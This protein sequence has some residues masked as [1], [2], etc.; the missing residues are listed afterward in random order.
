MIGRPDRNSARPARTATCWACQT[1]RTSHSHSCHPTQ[2]ASSARQTAWTKQERARRGFYS[3][4]NVFFATRLQSPSREISWHDAARSE[5]RYYDDDR[6][7]ALAS[8]IRRDSRIRTMARRLV[9]GGGTGSL[10]ARRWSP[11][12]AMGGAFRPAAQGRR[13]R[14]R[15]GR[16][17]R[18]VD[19]RPHRH[20]PPA[21]PTT[22]TARPGSP[23]CTACG[24][25]STR[26]WSASARRSPTIRN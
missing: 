18:P 7:G 1:G 22:S 4:G 9:L 19:R 6:C 15:G 23:I 3:I 12:P 13:R 10:S 16:A 25:W 8:A 24:R 14:P 11:A 20:R 5:S 26:W 2:L 17:M 21:T